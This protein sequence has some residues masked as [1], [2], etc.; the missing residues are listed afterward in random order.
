MQCPRLRVGLHVNKDVAIVG[1]SAAGFFTAYLLAKH[2]IRPRVFEAADRIGS[3]DRTLI[4]THRMYDVL[5][6]LCESAVVNKISRFDLMVNGRLAEIG[7][8]Q[9]DL[10]LERSTLIK[11]LAAKAEAAGTHIHTGT[12]FLTV[13]HHGKKL[14]LTLLRSGVGRPVEVSTDALVGSDGALS[15]VARDAGLPAQPTVYLNQAIV[16]L[17]RDMSPHTARVWFMPEETPYFFWLIPHSPTQGVLGLIGE[18]EPDTRRAL[19]HFLERKDLEPISFQSARIPLY[20]KWACNHRKIT[21]GNIYV[22]G[23]AAGHVKNSTVGGIV[24]GFR[25]ARGVAEAILDGGYSR[26]LRVLRWELD[27]HQ[28]I[29][30]VLNRFTPIDYVKLLKLLG[31]SDKSSLGSFSRDETGKLLPRLLLNN[32]RLLLL[33]IRSFL[34]GN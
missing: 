27:R 4:A 9:P 12:R 21:K 1:G 31:Q 20:V 30:K 28:L 34:T 32:P 17:P 14:R 16:D 7:L 26:E 18:G 15:A 24:A 33:G 5:G 3:L 2:G 10:V 29:R 19:M 22:A 6:T 8:E 13:K 11:T 23:D 25:G